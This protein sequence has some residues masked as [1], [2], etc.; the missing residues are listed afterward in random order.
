MSIQATY[1]P[2]GGG[3]IN[4]QLASNVFVSGGS[5]DGQYVLKEGS[6]AIGAGSGGSDMGIFGG[7][8]PYILSG[9]PG[10]PRLTSFLVPAT[11]TDSSGLTFE[12]S[13]EAHPE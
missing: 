7:A 10:I 11:A 13:A 9:I 12:V 4:G 8:T 3:N 5:F 2:E 6:P 1:L